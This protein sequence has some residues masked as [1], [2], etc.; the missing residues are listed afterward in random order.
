MKM[1]AAEA[2][3]DTEQPRPFSIFT[4]GALG[5]RRGGFA[6]TDPGP[7]VLPRHRRLRRRGPGINELRDQYEPTYGQD[8]GAA[9]YSPAATRRSSR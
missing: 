6:I 4:I 3:Y 2:L 5:R 9:Y 8:P 7:A 1:A